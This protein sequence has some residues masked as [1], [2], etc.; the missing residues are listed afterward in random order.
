MDTATD[1]ALAV[2]ALVEDEGLSREQAA[3]TLAA[4]PSTV[5]GLA[6]RKRAAVEEQ[7]RAEAEREYAASPAGR[8]AAA[9]AA[10]AA[11]QERERLA[12]GAR[13]LLARDGYP[14]SNLTS[15]EVLWAAGLERKPAGRL[16]PQDRDREAEALTRK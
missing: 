13:E 14:V 4:S 9:E 7:A 2:A 10:L 15:D 11:K 1:L 3:L 6:A 16:T 5:A 8:R 12:E